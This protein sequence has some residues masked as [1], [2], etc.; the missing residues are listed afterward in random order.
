MLAG[1]ALAFAVARRRGPAGTLAWVFAIL[2]FPIVGALAYFALANPYVRRPR[3]RKR[4]AN[5]AVREKNPAPTPPEPTVAHSPQVRGLLHAASRLTG[6]SPSGGNRVNLFNGGV[7][8]FGAKEAAI[9]GAQRAIWAE[10]YTVLDDTTGHRFLRLLTERAKDGIDVR[11]LVD[12]VGTGSLGEPL[13]ELSAAGG[14]VATFL[15][16]NPLRRR[17]AVHLRNHRKILVVD[18][19]TGFVGGMNVGDPYAGVRTAH[20]RPWRD[21]HLRVEGPAARDLAQVFDEDWT[22]MTGELLP[23][24]PPAEPVGTATVAIVPSGPDQREN[25]AG[26]LWFACLGAAVERCW[27]STPYFVPDEPTVRA[28]CAAALRGCDVRIVIPEVSDV[29]FMSFV[30]RSFFPRLVAAGVR[31]WLYEPGMMH[32][33][34][35]V[36]DD[37]LCL[38]G[39]ANVDVRSFRLN[40]EAG[41]L[42]ADR[43]VADR[44]ES[45]FRKDLERSREVTREHL[46]ARRPWVAV[47][48]GAAQLLSPLL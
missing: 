43:A 15:P 23:L 13:A 39:S 34:T 17:W 12:A 29:W 32:A 6:L 26:T 9:R 5:R 10:Y 37:D 31:V 11:L 38:V 25:A 3:R 14:R 19:H 42:V 28:L 44:L 1:T 35:L 36:I 48:E 8:A 24:L 4:A 7:D 2:A 18:G 16:V 46:R 47:A 30:N 45:G 41:A 27:I 33:K 20:E 22:F 40:F 21:A